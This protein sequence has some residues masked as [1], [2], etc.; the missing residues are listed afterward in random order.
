MYKTITTCATIAA[1]F[2]LPKPALAE[3]LALQPV[4]LGSE[5]VRYVHGQATIDLRQTNGVVE[6]T[7]LPPDHGALAFGVAVYNASGAPALVDSSSFTVEAGKQVLAAQTVDRLVHKAEHRA[8]WSKFGVGLLGSLAAGLAA[9]S[10]DTYSSTLYTHY[11]AYR[12]T[13]SAPSIVGQIQADRIIGHTSARIGDIQ[14]NL[15]ATRAQLGDSIIQ[16]TT[17]DPGR[18]YAGRIVFEKLAN[19]AAPQALTVRVNWNGEIYTFGFRLAKPG[20]PLPAFASIAPA[21]IPAASTVPEAGRVIQASATLASA[22]HPYVDRNAFP[23]PM[24]E[25][26]TRVAAVTSPYIETVVR[27]TADYYI[28]PLQFEDGSIAT[29]FSAEGS[30]LS[31]A[32]RVGGPQISQAGMLER[33]TRTIC[34]HTAMIP[35]IGQG[36]TISAALT[37]GNGQP[38][39]KV[40]LDVQ[41][42]NAGSATS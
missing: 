10:R 24:R 3:N 36:G 33:V 9:S 37:R 28:N 13:Y 8:G 4:Q 30:K 17:V 12:A 38:L 31:M 40:V 16:A 29:Q 25:G 41:S 22:A 42:C 20:T 35:V 21:P 6:I 1:A 15:D 19:S 5:T 18:S 32:V 11:G 14:D 39:G 23:R 27:K 7:T 26:M 34:T 2:L